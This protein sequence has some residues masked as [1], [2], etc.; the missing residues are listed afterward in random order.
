MDFQKALD[1]LP[2]GT[3]FDWTAHKEI[4]DLVFLCQHELDMHAEGEFRHRVADLYRFVDFI[5]RYGTKK[6]IEEAKKI[7]KEALQRKEFYGE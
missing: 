2:D 4:T 7:Y 1:E 6:E 5:G 3:G